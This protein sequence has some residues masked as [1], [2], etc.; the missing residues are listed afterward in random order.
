MTLKKR[1]NEGCEGV[2]G[3]SRRVLALYRPEDGRIPPTDFG[4]FG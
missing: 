4:E 2:A 3:S 1:G